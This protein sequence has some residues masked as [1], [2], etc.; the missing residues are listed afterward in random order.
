MD[1]T[2]I[3]TISL[4]FELFWGMRDK[5]TIEG[6][7]KNLSG[8]P[9]AIDKILSKFKQYDIHA[10][11]ASV[12]FLFYKDA[13]DLKNNLPQSTP[14]YKNKLLNPYAYLQE[15]S[16]EQKYH[17]APDVIQ[18]IANTKNQEI[19]THTMSHYYCLEE[20]QTKKEFFDDLTKAIETI[21]EKTNS[22]TYS[23]VFPRNQWNEEYL[24]VLSDLNIACYRGN[25][26]G[27]IYDAVN[28]EDENQLRRAVRLIDSYLN[29][30]GHNTYSL[31]EL[32]SNKPFNIPSSRFLRPV[33]NKLS[34][35]EPLRLRRIKKAICSLQKSCKSH[36]NFHLF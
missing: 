22:N 34:F 15:K 8:V 5:Q 12:G 27:W 13:N 17:F 21:K 26:N 36:G 3:I 30:S 10:T 23:L 35:A 6:Y 33:S 9:I 1:R 29:I 24:S 16:L 2:G 4:D 18:K 14:T 11:W 7:Q 25:E 20:G 19:G 32:S 31:K 28:G